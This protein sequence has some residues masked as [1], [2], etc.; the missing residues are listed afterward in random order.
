MPGHARPCPAMP[1][2]RQVIDPLNST[3]DLEAVA[4]PSSILRDGE[5][6]SAKLADEMAA[7]R[8]MTSNVARLE[9]V[10]VTRF[11]PKLLSI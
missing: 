3:A 9:F 11:G 4:T 6:M 8:T 5:Q 2:S 1:R 10:S 7:V